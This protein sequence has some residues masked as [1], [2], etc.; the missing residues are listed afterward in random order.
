MTG[1]WLT[2]YIMGNSDSSYKSRY[3]Y[4]DRGE[5]MFMGPVWDFDWGCGS[6][7]VRKW[8]TNDV[9]QVYLKDPSPTGWSPGGNVANFMAE[10]CS[11]PYFCMKVREK[12]L[13]IR[14][15]LTALLADGGT[16]D[17]HVDYIR[18]SGIANENR[19]FYR[20]GFSGPTGDAAVFKQFLKDRLAWLD[21]KFTTLDT[22]VANIGTLPRNYPLRPATSILTPS[23]P[24]HSGDPAPD[25]P[26]TVSVAVTD[27]RAATLDVFVNGRFIANAPV[28]NGVCTQEIPAGTL[29]GVPGANN[30]V[31]FLARTSAGAFLTNKISNANVA[32]RNYAPIV[33][34]GARTREVSLSHSV[35]YD[36]LND[37][38]PAITNNPSQFASD[39][40]YEG[41]A[42][43]TSPFG[44]SIPLWQDYVAGT[45]PTVATNIFSANIT[46]ENGE[47]KVTWNPD[48]NKDGQQRRVYTIKGAAE[49][50]DEFTAPTNSASRFFK[51]EVSLP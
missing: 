50:T 51:V 7:Q 38:C 46:F 42:E 11:S 44:K 9:G 22:T 15:Y 30:L 14:P 32:T 37:L 21:G 2:M 33:V 43:G 8:G 20:T 29:M 13:A 49:L 27:S 1:F 25:Q 19:W 34:S 39:A 12:Y 23:F 28:E 40:A 47:L 41:L 48:L 6:P 18:E 3:A 4:M 10:W 31:S 17:Q 24:G 5:K 45:D 35:P 26:L 36:Y 16:Y